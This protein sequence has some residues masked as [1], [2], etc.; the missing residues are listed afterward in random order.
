MNTPLALW[1]SNI[2]ASGTTS[3]LSPDPVRSLLT[4]PSYFTAP[5][6]PP[7]EY[8]VYRVE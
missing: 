6:L 7:R 3:K 4:A 5:D 1:V 2:M 8:I